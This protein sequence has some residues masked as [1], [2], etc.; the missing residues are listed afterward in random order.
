MVTS[1]VV[2]LADGRVNTCA[3][4]NVN[5]SL[6]IGNLKNDSLSYILS[7]ENPPYKELIQEQ[8]QNIFRPVCKSCDFH[9]SL[10]KARKSKV[11][12]Y[13]F[14]QVKDLLGNRSKQGQK[15]NGM[16]E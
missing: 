3:C 15:L 5:G 12:Y 8:M 13:H 6:M 2:I 10:Y 1:R 7:M 4:R 9:Q 16:E 14:E 11:P